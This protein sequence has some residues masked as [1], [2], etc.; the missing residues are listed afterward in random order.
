[1]CGNFIKGVSSRDAK[2]ISMEEKQL[3]IIKEFPDLFLD[4]FTRFPST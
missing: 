3:P 2:E 4:E 1:V